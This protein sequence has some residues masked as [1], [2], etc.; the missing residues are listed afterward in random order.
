MMSDKIVILIRFFENFN[1]KIFYDK[2]ERN[3]FFNKINAL[4]IF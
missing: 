4:Y 1:K 2:L 3:N